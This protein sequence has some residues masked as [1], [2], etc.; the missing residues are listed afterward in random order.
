M[1]LSNKKNKLWT[2]ETI[3]MNLR[4]MMLNERSQRQMATYYGIL[5]IG[6]SRKDGTD[7]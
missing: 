6:K 3:Q 5:D 2:Y 1:L 7:L 4:N